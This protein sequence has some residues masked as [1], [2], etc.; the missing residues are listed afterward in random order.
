MYEGWVSK[1][2][3]FYILHKTE[4]ENY[5]LSE[6]GPV[7][8]QG[9]FQVGEDNFWDIVLEENLLLEIVFWSVWD[10]Q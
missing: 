4:L 9:V 7:S 10:R 1:W 8:E 3:R 6:K 2:S 5:C